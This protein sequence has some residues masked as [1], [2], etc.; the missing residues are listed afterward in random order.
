MIIAN[1]IDLQ[2]NTTIELLQS[3]NAMI[4]LH[5]SSSEPDGFQYG[6]IKLFAP[7]LLTN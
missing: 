1:N 6:S 5:E 7:A 4:A 2:I 3:T